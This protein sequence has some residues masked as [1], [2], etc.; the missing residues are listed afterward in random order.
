MT[1]GIPPGLAPGA[2]LVL[3]FL[4]VLNFLPAF[5]GLVTLIDHLGGGE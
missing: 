3:G 5:L 2:V 4:I 1:R